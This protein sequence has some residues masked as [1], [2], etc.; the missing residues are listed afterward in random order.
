M[1]KSQNSRIKTECKSKS[2]K[3]II[4]INFGLLLSLTRSFLWYE[5]S[6]DYPNPAPQ[7]CSTLSSSLYLLSMD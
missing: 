4:I 6:F 5:S 1:L 3:I 2:V 7:S